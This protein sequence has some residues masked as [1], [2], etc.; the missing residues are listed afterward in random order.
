MT[1]SCERDAFGSPRLGADTVGSF[2]AHRLDTIE[3]HP[4]R[5]GISSTD[6]DV[7]DG[8]P[9][10]MMAGEFSSSVHHLGA[11]AREPA[12]RLACLGLLGSIVG[13]LVDGRYGQGMDSSAVSVKLPL[14]TQNARAAHRAVLAYGLPD[15]PETKVRRSVN[16]AWRWRSGD[17]RLPQGGPFP[18]RRQPVRMEGGIR[19]QS[20]IGPNKGIRRGCPAL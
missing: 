19:W 9:T 16:A 18:V 13:A 1:G 8:Y 15:S 17:R 12:N 14:K 20:A 2:A 3:S 7:T 6:K 11:V 4:V 10:A 5:Q